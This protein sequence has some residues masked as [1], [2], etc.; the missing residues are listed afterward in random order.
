MLLGPR[1]DRALVDAYED[2]L[3][4]E[5]FEGRPVEI[6]PRRDSDVVFVGIGD[7]DERPI[8][9]FGDGI[10]SLIILIFPAF[11]A[12][13]R[14]LLFIEEPDTHLH[15]GMQR[16]LLELFLRHENLR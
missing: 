3:A 6:R 2:F 16:K 12:E 9:Q 5:L 10:Q 15:P 4:A 7:D 13:K 8:Y 14:S 11:V 1:S